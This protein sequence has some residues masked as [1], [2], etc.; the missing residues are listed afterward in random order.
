MTAERRKA[1]T[2][3][4]EKVGLPIVLSVITLIGSAVGAGYA[5]GL[6]RAAIQR[7]AADA[8]RMAAQN[9]DAAKVRADKV[10]SKVD[11]IVAGDANQDRLIDRCLS[12]QEAMSKRQDRLEATHRADVDELRH[13]ISR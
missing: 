7:D 3:L 10:D 12:A 8:K 2:A 4:G 13:A 6:D 11:K 9:S 1:I 5:V